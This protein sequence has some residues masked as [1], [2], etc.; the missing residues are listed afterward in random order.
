MDRFIEVT[1]DISKHYG[2]SID[3]YANEKMKVNELIFEVLKGL[4]LTLISI[5]NIVLKVE[6][7]GLILTQ[8]EILVSGDIRDGDVLILI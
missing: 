8:S 3:I 1:V 4:N 2:L 5:D 7:S 6:R